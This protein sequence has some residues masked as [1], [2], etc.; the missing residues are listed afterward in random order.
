[1]TLRLT[2]FSFLLVFMIST[3]GVSQSFEVYV[4]DAGNFSSG[5]KIYKFDENGENPE[6]FIDSPLAWPQDIVFLED[7]GVVLISS[8]NSGNIAKHDIET[9]AY[10]EDFATGINGPTRMK[11]GADSLL[12]VL[13]WTETSPVLRY[14]LDGT[15]VDEFT[16]LGVSRSIG[17]DWDDDG[18]L[19]VSSFDGSVR[20]F[21]TDGTHLGIFASSNL[22]GPTNIF[23]ND[24]GDLIVLDW[25]QG[26]IKRFDA[27]GVYQGDFITGLAN[28]EGVAFL[29]NGNMLIGNGG[30]GS[31]KEFD[32]EGNFVKDF[33]APGSGGLSTP[34]AV[35]IRE[36]VVNSVSEPEEVSNYI[37]PTVGTAFFLNPEVA[38]GIESVEVYNAAGLRVAQRNITDNQIW[39][40]T[41]A[42]AGVYFIKMTSTDGAQKTQKVVVKK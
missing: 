32:F 39:N 14:Q 35:V 41:N 28:P 22:S 6:V 17:I 40:A 23:F 12:Y 33:I 1:M 9:G 8:L 19:Y 31:V 34:N 38:Q 30:D 2:T 3:V 26:E 29:P 25:N 16:S 7:Q 37:R 4:S 24:N 42:P 11:I 13:Q 20:Q 36:L 5:F 18:K 10:I 27:S 15:F 21:D